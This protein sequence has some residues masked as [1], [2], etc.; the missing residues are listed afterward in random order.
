MRRLRSSGREKGMAENLKVRG[1]LYA[2]GY[3]ISQRDVSDAIAVLRWKKLTFGVPECRWFLFSDER[4][5]V[6]AREQDGRFAVVLGTALDPTAKT[7]EKEAIIDELLARAANRERL[8]DYIDTLCGRHIIIVGDASGAKLVQDAC[9]MRTCYYGQEFVASHYGL[10]NDLERHAYIPFWSAYN[11]MPDKPWYLP[12]ALT[13]YEDVLTL[14]PNHALDLRTHQIERIFPRRPREAIPASE[15]ADYFAGLMRTQLEVLSRKYTFLVSATGGHDS[16][17]TLSA[18]RPYR[19]K[20]LVFS[21][22]NQSKTDTCAHDNM[23]ARQLSEQFGFAYRQ[24]VL[25]K[26]TPTALADILLRNHYHRH[27]PSVIPKYVS[28]LPCEGALHLRSN[29][30]EIIRE[31]AYFRLKP[32]TAEAMAAMTYGGVRKMGTAP[33]VLK[34]FSDFFRINQYDQ[35]Q[36]YDAGDVF[37]QE[38]RMGV[39]HAGGVLLASDLAFD[40]YCLF[41]QRKLVDMGMRMSER[42]RRSNYLVDEVIKRLWPEMSFSLPNSSETLL[43]RKSPFSR[44]YCPAFGGAEAIAQGAMCTST[45]APEFAEVAFAS[46]DIKKGAFVGVRLSFNKVPVGFG[47]TAIM[48]FL[49]LEEEMAESFTY[50]VL[51]NGELSVSESLASLNDGYAVLQVGLKGKS[52]VSSVEVQVVAM[53]DFACLDA[54]P[55]MRLASWRIVTK[56]MRICQA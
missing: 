54:V 43:D 16:R 51:V 1:A 4:N 30:L 17:T 26:P 21:Y 12:G 39:W 49:S 35:L 20:A 41:N 38:L 40:T 14:F 2:R 7:L 24:L 33:E 25:D 8:L 5:E 15:V 44:G 45:L 52:P 29:I 46:G 55:V 48:S 23:A 47:V 32:C 42:F 36:G 19:E 22:L 11:A 37:Y 9:G 31:R 56:T 3:L 28:E 53:K 6:C 27:V 18:L 13:P 34:A 50:K 10:I